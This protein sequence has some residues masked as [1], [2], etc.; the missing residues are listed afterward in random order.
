MLLE[1]LNYIAIEGVIGAGK[2]TL[3]DMLA[4][5]L[6]AKNI[7]EEFEENPFLGD[8]Y[9]DQQRYAF[10][11]QIFFLLSRFRQLESLK[12]TDLFQKKVVSDYIFEKD[13]IFA[14]LTLSNKELNIL[15]T[16]CAVSLVASSRLFSK[17]GV[18]ELG[19]MKLK[20]V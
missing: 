19:N 6:G 7:L 17:I 12:Q 16:R 3:A 1:K 5:T 2:T 20:A 15:A 10:Q 18:A 8:F 13:R 11:T 9:N 4:R 14:T